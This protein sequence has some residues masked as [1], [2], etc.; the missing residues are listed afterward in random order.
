MTLVPK[1]D[2]VGAPLLAGTARASGPLR[3]YPAPSRPSASPTGRRGRR[4]GNPARRAAEGAWAALL[5]PSRQGADCRLPPRPVDKSP[6][7]SDIML[8]SG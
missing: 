7:A 5:A 1:P 6:S 4:R 3:P 8:S 2:T